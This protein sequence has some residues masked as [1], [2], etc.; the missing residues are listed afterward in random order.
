VNAL[1]DH[2][3]KDEMYRVYITD[4]LKTITE[5]TAKIAGGSSMKRRWFDIVNPKNEEPMQP[6]D[7]CDFVQSAL[8]KAKIEVV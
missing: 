8:Y 2:K 6:K 3:V 1:I 7:V 4:A 5:N